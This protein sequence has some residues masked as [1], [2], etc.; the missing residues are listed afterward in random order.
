M[1]RFMTA[2]E[3]HG[4]C[5]TGMLEG[6]PAALA[7]DKDFIDLQLQRRQIGYG[8]GA[9]MRIEKDEIEITAGVRFGRTLGSP[10][11]FVIDNRDW[12]NWENIMSA[13]P[14]IEGA[15]KR[16]VTRPRPGHVDLAGA[17]KYHTYDARDVL[18]RASA[19]ETAAR[20]S[21]GAFCQLFLRSFGIRIGSHVVAV[22]SERV[23][24][25]FESLDAEKIFGIDPLSPMR[26]ADPA[27]EGRMKALIDQAKQTG[28]TLG[29][30]IEAVACSVPPGLGT[31]TQ[32]DR[33]LDGRLAQA[34]MSIP[35]AKG[36]E[37][38]EGVAGASRPGS[39]VHDEIFYGQES[40][41]FYRNTNRAGGV[42]A[43]I[44]NG[45]D[46]RVR[47]YM[48]PIPTLRKAL[49]SVDLRTKEAFKAQFERS[50]TCVVPAAAVIAE[51]MLAIV[52]S[53]AFL[54]KFGGDTI[55]ETRNNLSGYLEA[56]AEY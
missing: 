15:D 21:G 32:W 53:E 33:R 45:S 13:A 27:A 2:G 18:E 41:R 14:V 47:V 1:L 42:E 22:G 19:R 10:V 5:L 48:K 28:D 44:T 29:G 31:H 7:V 55:E 24:G 37:I 51:A 6:L 50:D 43:G 4:K 34:M 25:E 8:R 49:M 30:V 54:E 12:Q 3:S 38:G 56:L 36:V 9:R 11:C 35:A 17:L 46:V 26:C 40:H 20:V 39:A 23:S 16:A 52:L